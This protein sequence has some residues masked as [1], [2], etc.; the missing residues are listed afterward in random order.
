MKVECCRVDPYRK[1]FCMGVFSIHYAKDPWHLVICNLGKLGIQGLHCFSS[2]MRH[3][4]FTA[5][6]LCEQGVLHLEVFIG[7]LF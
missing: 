2:S 7:P 1:G 4:E 5:V 6:T 3:K